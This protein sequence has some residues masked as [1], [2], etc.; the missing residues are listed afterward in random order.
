MRRS[1]RQSRQKYGRGDK[2]MSENTGRIEYIEEVIK[3]YHAGIAC[4]NEKID[5]L[6][7]E[8]KRIKA[9]K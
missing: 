5:R 7:Q 8:I 9:K 1:A 6:E 4:Y 2:I 3:R